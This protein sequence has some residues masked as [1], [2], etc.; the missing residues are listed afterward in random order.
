MSDEDGAAVPGARGSKVQSLQNLCE[1]GFSILPQRNHDQPSFVSRNPQVRSTQIDAIFTTCSGAEGSLVLSDSRL[2]I[3]TD[4]E[5]ISTHCRDM[6]H[7][8][9]QTR[10]P[11]QVTRN[12]ELPLF[13]TQEALE[14]LARNRDPTVSLGFASRKQPNNLVN[15]PNA[16]ELAKPGSTTNRP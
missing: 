4:H 14:D 11:R 8:P 10:G 2:S 7:K 6:A 12:F 13:I 16:A 5:D 3:G 15:K 9:R 1:W